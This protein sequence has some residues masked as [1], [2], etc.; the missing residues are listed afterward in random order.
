M[1]DP[2]NLGMALSDR[3]ASLLVENRETNMQF[4]QWGT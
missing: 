2:E 4:W 1:I 3:K